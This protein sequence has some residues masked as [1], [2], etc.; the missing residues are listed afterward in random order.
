MDQKLIDK[1]KIRKSEGT[2][3]SLSCFEGF[4]DFYSNDYLGL[5]KASVEDRSSNHSGATGSRLISGNSQEAETCERTLA[6]FFNSEAAL[7]YNSGYDANVGLFSAILQRGDT[8]LYDEAIHASVRDGIRLSFASA[9]S[10]EHNSLNDLRLKLER[11]K[12]TIYIAVESLYSMNGDLAPLKEIAEISAEYNAYLIVDEAHSGGVFGTSGRGLVEELKLEKN[13]FARLITFGKAYGCH[14]AVVLGSQNLK[15]FLI[16]FSRSFIYTT[17]LPP[18]DYEIIKRKVTDTS[19][20]MRQRELQENIT[21]FN[22]NTPLVNRKSDSRSPI[23]MIRI[24]S[25]E[26]TRS[27][28]EQLQKA[29]IA[30]KPIY[31]PTVKKGEESIRICIHANN[32]S[33]EIEFLSDLINQ[34]I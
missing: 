14:G 19:I 5:S 2:L 13:V 20:V 12:G 7:V 27:I 16:N 4:I 8:I 34:L 30:I 33:A 23:Q 9:Y 10:F 32:S 1:L 22:S 26:K 15:E 17:A 29:K 11:A 28:A 18:D 25:I 31:N 24:G 3:R 21:L 6:E